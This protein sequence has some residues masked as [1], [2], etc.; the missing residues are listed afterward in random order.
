MKLSVVGLN[1]EPPGATAL[2]LTGPAVSE[3]SYSD[4]SLILAGLDDDIREDNN[5]NGAVTDEDHKNASY[6]RS[7]STQAM[8]ADQL[9]PETKNFKGHTRLLG[10]PI[11]PETGKKLVLHNRIW[12]G[13]KHNATVDNE[14]YL[15]ARHEPAYYKEKGDDGEEYEGYRHYV[16]WE[17]AIEEKVKKS[18]DRTP[19]KA[20]PQSDKKKKALA[21]F[22]AASKTS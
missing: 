5:G 13:E 2:E 1:A 12:Q 18:L 6:M 10:S 11:D 7:E 21:R 4:S 8:F 15:K 20:A 19:T 22:K 9:D 14:C 3:A 16:V 17:I